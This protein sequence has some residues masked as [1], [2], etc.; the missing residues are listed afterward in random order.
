MN[1]NMVF[2]PCAF[3]DVLWDHISSLNYMDKTCSKM[4]DS[5]YEQL[6]VHGGTTFYRCHSYR[7]CIR[8]ACLICVF[9]NDFRNDHIYRMKLNTED[10]WTHIHWI[11]VNEVGFCQHEYLSS[12][13][14]LEPVIDILVD[15]LLN[16]REFFC[17]RKV[18]PKIKIEKI[19]VTNLN[20]KILFEF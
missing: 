4:P 1:R 17:S 3:S 16:W 10:I 6:H 2:R 13:V 11:F 8:M 15:L 12:S 9:Y 18:A 5:R 14:T 7:K 19:W 20:R